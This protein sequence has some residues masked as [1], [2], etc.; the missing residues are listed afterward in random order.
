MPSL[1]T[2]SD[3]IKNMNT[4]L[5]N[6]NNK[7]YLLYGQDLN[8]FTLFTT[9]ELN[10]ECKTFGQYIIECL[11]SI[12][13]NIDIKSIDVLDNHIEFWIQ[14]DKNVH[15]LMLFPCDDIIIPI[16]E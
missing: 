1:Q 15:Y 13:N 10:N 6:T 3:E 9:L 7:F 5:K 12:D 16:G 4:F 11:K 14:N 8:Y 2:Y